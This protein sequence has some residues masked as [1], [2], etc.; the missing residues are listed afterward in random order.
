MSIIWL[1]RHGQASFGT[2]DYD[3]LSEI[4]IRQSEITGG[5]FKHTGVNFDSLYSGKMKRQIDTAK[6]ALSTMESE[7]EA[8]V[9]ASF[10]E[11]DFKSIIDSQ[12]PG[13]IEN[14]PSV[15][16][17][18]QNIFNDNKSFQRVFSKIM[19]RWIS[20]KYD[21]ENVERYLDYK[22]RVKTGLFQIAEENHARSTIAVFTS[23]G[24]ASLVMQL[25]LNL[26]DHE[27]MELGWQ[28]MNGSVSKFKYSNGRLSLL[29]F[30]QLLH[31][32][33]E[34]I[35]ELLTYR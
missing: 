9:K 1:I 3:R 33:Y 8:I 15:S 31:L 24:V 34:A 27:A 18:L 21:V 12:L 22:L 30:N 20:G 14:D 16:D 6:Y 25:A 32:E 7:K 5:F 13:L 26:S 23:A 4:G 2:S 35:P 10:D 17:D 11:Y 19:E 29:I 28:I